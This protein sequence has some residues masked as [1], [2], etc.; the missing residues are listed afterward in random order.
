MIH[1]I[2]HLAGYDHESERDA[3]EMERVETEVLKSLGI[4]DPYDI[5]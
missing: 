2:L 4:P 3:K 5:D 1:A